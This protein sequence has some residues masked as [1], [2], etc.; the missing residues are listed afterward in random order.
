[1]HR[2]RQGERLAHSLRLTSSENEMQMQEDGI[3]FM[4]QMARL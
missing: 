1:M 2:Q 3:M 4:L